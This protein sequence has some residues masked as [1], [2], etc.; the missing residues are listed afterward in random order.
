MNANGVTGD[1]TLTCIPTVVQIVD[2]NLSLHLTFVP[3]IDI[4]NQMVANV[5]ADLGK[6]QVKFRT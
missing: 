1:A 6:T 5:I 3:S 2:R 4:S